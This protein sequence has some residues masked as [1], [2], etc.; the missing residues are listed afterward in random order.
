M[1]REFYCAQIFTCIRTISLDMARLKYKA[2]A[3]NS[4]TP[5]ID[6]SILLRAYFWGEVSIP[7]AE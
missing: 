3:Q 6:N 1:I 4:S 7:Q 2:I 5:E